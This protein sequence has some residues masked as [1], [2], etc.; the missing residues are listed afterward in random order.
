MRNQ[1][2]ASHASWE[3]QKIAD[4]DA[5]NASVEVSPRKIQLPFVDARIGAYVSSAESSD[6]DEEVPNARQQT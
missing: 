1:V 3:T 2:N 4:Q 5:H 6:K